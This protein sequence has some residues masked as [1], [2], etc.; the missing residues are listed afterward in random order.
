MRIFNQVLV[1]LI[2]LALI[3]GSALGIV[4]LVG[5][6]TGTPALTQMVNGW[7]QSIAELNT[8]QVQ[9]ILLGSFL[10]FIVLLVLELIPWRARFIKVRDDSVGRT[11]LFRADM[12]RYLAQ[13]LLK[14][15]TITPEGVEVIVHGDTFE[16]AAGVAIP[17]DMDR[18]E[19][20]SR[21][22]QNVRSN[23]ESIG[24][25]EGLERVETR[26]TRHKRVA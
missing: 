11:Q 26:V 10:V 9:A 7:F 20:Q 24:L 1:T 13:R 25:E 15:K 8:G 18:Q 6:L 17:L 3:A 12:E 21:V 16:V 14:E 19:V 5:F 2:S 22:E 23:L 4:Y